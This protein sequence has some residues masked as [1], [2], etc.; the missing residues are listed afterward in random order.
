MVS[1]RQK[2][3]LCSLLVAT[4]KARVS[5]RTRSENNSHVTYSPL[6]KGGARWGSE[7]QNRGHLDAT[8]IEN[9]CLP[10]SF[11]P[12]PPTS[13]LSNPSRPPRSGTSLAVSP[14]PGSYCDQLRTALAQEPYSR[15]TESLG[16]SWPQQLS[17]VN[18]PPS[19]PYEILG[20]TLWS[21]AGMGRAWDGM[22]SRR[23]SPSLWLSCW[24]VLYC[25]FSP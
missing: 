22:R 9:F 12:S 19:L 2:K 14:S 10:S 8:K 4:K 7:R 15:W 16:S 6:T 21:C 5:T 3:S 17:A 23:S 13:R 11:R 25:F 20:S 24:L 18:D 1:I